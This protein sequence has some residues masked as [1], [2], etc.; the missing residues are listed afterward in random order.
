MAMEHATS[1]VSALELGI[2]GL[3]LI[4]MWKITDAGKQLFL[5]SK[6]PQMDPA[7]PRDPILGQ[8]IKEIH[9]YTE[10]VQTQIAQGEFQCQWRDRDE[11]RDF[12][13]IMKNQITASKAQTRAI[14]ELTAEMR[15]TRNGKAKT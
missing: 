14:N 3:A 5:A 4:V 6:V 8:Y 11:V 13:E 1:A 2:V 12:M 10:T 7:C 9:D 15:A